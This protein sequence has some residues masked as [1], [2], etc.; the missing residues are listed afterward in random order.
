[1]PQSV[2]F[3]KTTYNTI[4]VIIQDMQVKTMSYSDFLPFHFFHLLKHTHTRDQEVFFL[5]M[6]TGLK[7]ASSPKYLN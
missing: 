5:L 4:Q 7:Q 6:A 1:M 2:L 3:S